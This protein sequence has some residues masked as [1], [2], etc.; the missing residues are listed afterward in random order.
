[1]SRGSS[2]AWVSSMA[3]KPWLLMLCL[4]LAIVLFV[5]TTPCTAAR[6]LRSPTGSRSL[7]T[8][9]NEEQPE[10][11]IEGELDGVPTS[12]LESGSD[13]NDWPR[14]RVAQEVFQDYNP[15]TANPDPG[16]P[17]PNGFQS[18]FPGCRQV[19]V[20]KNSSKQ[21]L[22]NRLKLTKEVSQIECTPH[23]PGCTVRDQN[24]QRRST[25]VH[26]FLKVLR[27]A[28]FGGSK[29]FM[30]RK[31]QG[32]DDDDDDDDVS[33]QIHVPFLIHSAHPPQSPVDL[34]LTT[35]HQVLD[36]SYL[37]SDLTGS[38]ISC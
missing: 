6:G 24:A 31:W 14:Y 20:P 16:I 36:F 2:T 22:V 34:F 28:N 29:A 9:Y 21:C 4:S 1:M 27:K 33:T 23:H 17:L 25:P 18:Y 26:N 11:M 35:L 38:L 37:S 10:W 5:V 7:L 19:T 15:A 8:F 13:F 12:S 30:P 32:Y 3:R